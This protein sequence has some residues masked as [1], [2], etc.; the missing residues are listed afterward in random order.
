MAAA[1]GEMGVA[2]AARTSTQS[3]PEETGSPTRPPVRMSI[4]GGRD[5]SQEGRGLLGDNAREVLDP[6]ST[7]RRLQP[8]AVASSASHSPFHRH[9]RTCCGQEK[10]ATKMLVH[11]F[12]VLASGWTR[13]G[14]NMS[15]EGGKE[16][17]RSLS[18]ASYRA[19]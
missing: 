7:A 19:R 2:A 10:G 3:N 1:V 5:A 14:T 17:R 16:E 8:H 15:E 4:H 13:C 12:R 6:A 18:A 11:L 9:A